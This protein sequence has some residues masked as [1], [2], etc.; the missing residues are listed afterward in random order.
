MRWGDRRPMVVGDDAMLFLGRVFYLL[1][2][3]TPARK[4]STWL[5]VSE[6][7]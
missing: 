5:L 3:M 7:V 6:R 4:F 1:S 2:V